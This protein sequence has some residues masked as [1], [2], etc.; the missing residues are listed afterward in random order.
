MRQTDSSPALFLFTEYF[1]L[2][3]LLFFYRV[4]LFQMNRSLK[5]WGNFYGANRFVHIETA[6]SLAR[7]S[8]WGRCLAAF[9]L[10]GRLISRAI[11]RNP[12]YNPPCLRYL[13]MELYLNP[14]A[15]SER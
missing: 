11:L 6:T 5:L 7:C 10:S 9:S 12:G 13:L 1:Y 2:L 15:G 3:F 8:Y 4:L 14:P